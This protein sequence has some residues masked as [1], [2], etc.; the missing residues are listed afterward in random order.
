M[1]KVFWDKD[2]ISFIGNQVNSTEHSHCVL[3][4]F[5]SFDEPLQI[6][7]ENKT[8]IGKCIVVNKNVRH[9]FSCNGSPR[10]SILIEPTSSF[11][12]ELILKLN[13]SYLICDKENIGQLQQKA[14]ALVNAVSK[15]QYL[16]FVGDFAKYLGIVRKTQ[17]LDERI[18][19]LLAILQRCDCY[20][21][22]IENFA[23]DVCLSSSRLS[24]LFREQIGVS[25]KSY[26]LFHQLE[27][28]FTALLNGKSITDAALLAGF[29]SPSHFA[30]TV[31]NWMGLP[32]SAY[33]K[34]SE[35][36]KVFI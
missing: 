36:L 27:K 32:V 17:V 14:A 15:E 7:I 10:L 12:K 26:I 13:G 4:A 8:V 18:T 35:F 23:N 25:L 11:A 28:A 30:T 9:A 33:I 2:N 20:D 6:I 19:E 5:L 21:H 1:L 29:D 16:Q 34:D 22:T 24:H 3:Q 31:K